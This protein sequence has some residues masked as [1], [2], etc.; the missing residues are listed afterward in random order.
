MPNY[1]ISI[2]LADLYEELSEYS[3]REHNGPFSLC[4][5]EADNP[6][7][8]CSIVMTRLMLSIVRQQDTVETRILCR[9][10]RRYL[11]ID[12]VQCL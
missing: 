8:A 7:E 4:I 10:I 1:R 6:D 3:L 5:L 9:K 12:K 2:D 11:R